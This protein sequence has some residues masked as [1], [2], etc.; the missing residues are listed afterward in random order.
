MKF[1][2][3][4]ENVAGVLRR[5][6]SSFGEKLGEESDGTQK[7][8]ELILTGKLVAGDYVFVRTMGER[9]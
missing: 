4:T 8:I 2:S 9:M 1:N 7:E 3:R 5:K 6:T